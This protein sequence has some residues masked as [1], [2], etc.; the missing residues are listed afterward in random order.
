MQNSVPS[1]SNKYGI[2]RK[3][4]LQLLTS[5][6]RC[7]SNSAVWHLQYAD[8]TR[9][10][11][12]TPSAGRLRGGG[13]PQRPMPERMWPDAENLVRLQRGSK[14]CSA[15]AACMA[16]CVR[17]T[18]DLRY[19]Q[20][21]SDCFRVWVNRMRPKMGLATDGSESTILSTSE[22]GSRILY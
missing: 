12:P 3:L 15:S 13:P 9:A 21:R 18:A 16:S 20:S 19:Q 8:V 2:A 1:L 17:P 22:I 14:P 7:I 5:S 11:P 10:C 6:L 4:H